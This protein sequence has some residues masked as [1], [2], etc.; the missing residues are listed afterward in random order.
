MHRSLKIAYIA[1]LVFA[2]GMGVHQQ[3]LSLHLRNLGA[4]AV[5]WGLYSSC[6]LAFSALSYFP[7]AWLCNKFD[8]KTLI[9][10]GWLMA[11]PAPL[12]YA[13]APSWPWALWGSF[14]FNISLF[15]NVALQGYIIRFADPQKISATLAQI[16]AAFSLGSV[17]SQ[18]LGGYLLDKVGYTWVFIIAAVFYTI[19]TIMYCFIDNDPPSIEEKESKGIGLSLHISRKYWVMIISF[20]LIHSLTMLPLDFVI[21]YIKDVSGL[22]LFWIGIVSAAASLGG[23]F[24]SPILGKISDKSGIFRAI[25]LNLIL[26]AM[27]MLLLVY[28]PK[29]LPALLFS[30][31]LRGG[32]RTN[33]LYAACLGSMATPA[34]RSNLLSLFGLSASLFSVVDPIISGALY[35]MEMA[36]PFK[37]TALLTMIVAIIISLNHGKIQAFVS[38]DVS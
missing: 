10:A 35:E 3:F 34:E 20:C 30:S 13:Y 31:V 29:A 9:I 27:A 15:S 32:S 4:D 33:S 1:N 11:I 22:D 28:F 8:R 38:S 5:A 21:P 19:S 6:S 37:I 16:F 25:A 24:L 2:L 12:I 14:L 17:F 26:S 18:P 36:L 7:A 23:A